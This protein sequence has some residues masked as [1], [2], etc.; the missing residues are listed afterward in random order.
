M[1]Y[2]L[3]VFLSQIV[4]YFHFLILG[5]AIWVVSEYLNACYMPFTLIVY[6]FMLVNYYGLSV[7]FYL[8][9]TDDLITATSLYWH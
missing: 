2:I 1:L 5:F 4:F 8:S 7:I 3:N 6:T 9:L